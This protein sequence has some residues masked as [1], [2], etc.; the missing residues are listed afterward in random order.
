VNPNSTITLTSF[1]ATTNQEVCINAP[2]DNITYATTIAT[3]ATFS[4]LPAGVTGNWAA[5]VVTISGTP[6][7]LGLFNYII[8]LTGGCG[9]PVQ[10]IGSI[11]TN[12]RPTPTLSGPASMCINTTGN[13]YTTQ[14]G[15]GEYTWTIPSGNT[16]TGGG[17]GD[18]TATVNWLVAGA[19]TISV[20]Y[21]N[22]YGCAALVPASVAVTVI[23]N[24]SITLTSAAGTNAQT[25]PINSAITPITYGFNSSVT[26]AGVSGLPAGVT[27][28][29]S[30]G[31]MTISGTPSMIGVYNYTVTTTGSCVQATAMGTITVIGY[32]ISGTLTYDK[33]SVLPMAG[34][35]VQLK[36]GAEPVP[37]AIAPVPTVLLTATTDVNGYYEFYVPNGS[38]YV[39]ATN[40]AAWPSA[41]VVSN[42]VTQLQRYVAGLLP[43]TITGNPLRVRAADIN[44]DGFVNASDVTPLQRR[45]AGLMPNPNY[46]A[47]NWMFENPGVVVSGA[48]VPKN[49]KG[50]A[51]GDLNGSYPNP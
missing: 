32:K 51:S 46:K 18:N 2:I 10:A 22:V 16:Y 13:V 39:Y 31:T 41:A 48:D 45:I 29:Y 25:I 49:F 36:N 8:T 17:S 34:V 19:Q 33:A 40:A 9:G 20:N 5:N 38:Y 21:K 23:P 14:A 47:P 15:F 6:S 27:G 44:Q 50:I 37:P 1:I 30:M 42:D 35:T 28:I 4:G 43:N 24:A 3:G 7:E 12:P 11:K 26:G